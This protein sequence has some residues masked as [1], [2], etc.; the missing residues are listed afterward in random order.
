MSYNKKVTMER[1]GPNLLIEHKGN[2]T[3]YGNKGETNFK[4]NLTPVSLSLNLIHT[5][6]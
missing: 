2:I 4:V 5:L 1:E 3:Q 6:D